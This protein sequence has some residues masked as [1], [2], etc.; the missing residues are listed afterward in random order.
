MEQQ[1]NP[2]FLEQT[3]PSPEMEEQKQACLA[4]N[5]HNNNEQFSISWFKQQAINLINL[6][7]LPCGSGSHISST[8]LVVWGPVEQEPGTLV[9]PTLWWRALGNI[10]LDLPKGIMVVVVAT[11]RAAIPLCKSQSLQV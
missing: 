11:I 2:K 4:K 10:S 8:G 9:I 1:Y 6:P 5:C 3:T 7:Y